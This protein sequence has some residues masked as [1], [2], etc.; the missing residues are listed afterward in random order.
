M[1]YRRM[2]ENVL[3]YA[4]S[5]VLG[6]CDIGNNV[7]ISAGVKIIGENIPDCS[8]VFG[9]TP[10]L[11]IKDVSVEEIRRKQSHIW[12]ESNGCSENK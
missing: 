6:N 11:T 4:N 10:C 1:V 2:G 12:E 9:C 3:M 5:S 8:I 7:I